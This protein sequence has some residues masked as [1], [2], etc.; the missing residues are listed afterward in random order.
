M[1][2]DLNNRSAHA[3]LKEADKESASLDKRGEDR[4]LPLHHLLPPWFSR[5]SPVSFTLAVRCCS[6]LTLLHPHAS[7]RQADRWL[8]RRAAELRVEEC[9]RECSPPGGSTAPA[10]SPSLSLSLLES[11]GGTATGHCAPR[12]CLLAADVTASTPASPLSN[13]K[14]R[15][16]EDAATR[17]SSS[18]HASSVTHRLRVMLYSAK[19][20]SYEASRGISQENPMRDESTIRFAAIYLILATENL[21][22]FQLFSYISGGYASGHVT[23]RVRPMKTVVSFKTILKIRHAL[24]PA[25]VRSLPCTRY[26]HGVRRAQLLRGTAGSILRKTRDIAEVRW[27]M[28]SEKAGFT[29]PCLLGWETRTVEM[30]TLLHHEHEQAGRAWSELQWKRPDREQVDVVSGD[31]RTRDVTLFARTRASG[32]PT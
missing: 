18:T 28:P 16:R 27:A 5:G 22:N 3:Q 19:W 12:R 17:C 10:L 13:G 30:P 1:A 8:W 4:L 15:R 11:G 6:I 31:L 24:S 26:S 9:G 25:F 29:V 14:Y 2:A 20:I 7:S 32:K 23:S 21:Q